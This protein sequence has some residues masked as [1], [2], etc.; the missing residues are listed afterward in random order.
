M[1]QLEFG[2]ALVH[3]IDLHAMHALGNEHHKHRHREN[4]KFVAH[5]PS[6]DRIGHIDVATNQPMSTDQQEHGIGGKRH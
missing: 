4:K 2:V 1:C 6:H 3:L 5:C